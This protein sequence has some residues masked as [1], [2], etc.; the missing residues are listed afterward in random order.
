MTKYEEE[1]SNI[2]KIIE[3]FIKIQSQFKS[4]QAQLTIDGIVLCLELG[5]FLDIKDG[6]DELKH[7]LLRLKNGEISQSDYVYFASRELEELSNK[8]VTI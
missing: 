4:G 5:G 3:I 8:N 1:I 2:K 6:I 7:L